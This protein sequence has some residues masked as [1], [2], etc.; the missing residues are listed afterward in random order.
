MRWLVGISGYL[1]LAVGL[2]VLGLIGFAVVS[3][4]SPAQPVGHLWFALD[5]GSLNALQVVLER[6]LWPPL[7]EYL[8]FPFLMLPAPWAAA[9][10]LVP[11]IILAGYAW[12]GRRRH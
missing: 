10:A 3:G 12:L 7:W 1:M 8:A 5:A 11:G 4:L 6:Y 2:G 9:A